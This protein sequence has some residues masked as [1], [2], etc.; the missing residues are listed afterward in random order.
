MTELTLRLHPKQ[1]K[2]QHLGV[3][4][5]LEALRKLDVA[6]AGPS[7]RW[8]RVFH[9][10][11]R[12]KLALTFPHLVSLRL[13]NLKQG[14]IVLS[15]PKLAM[16]TFT[17]TDFLHIM[18]RDAALEKLTL[19][20]CKY[21]KLTLSPLEVR[22]RSLKYLHVSE[23]DE[24][25]RP[26]IEDVAHMRQ[27]QRLEYEN[28]PATSMPTSFPQNLRDVELLPLTWVCDLPR[29]IRELHNL[30]YLFFDAH[31]GSWEI[32]RPLCELL[33]IDCLEKLQLDDAYYSSR[34]ELEALGLWS[35]SASD[36]A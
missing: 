34:Q 2:A 33:P 20:E 12:G 7:Y 35:R 8:P 28:F 17:Q 19:V 30:R 14:E 23:C 22:L 13:C 25:G 32:V 16:V 9:A 18:V 21:L 29:G 10:V 1:G 27:L 26:L 11:A 36:G 6:C 15:C 3:L 5:V 4:G 24:E 31:Y